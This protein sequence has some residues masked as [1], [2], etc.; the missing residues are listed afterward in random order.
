MVHYQPH[1]SAT[2][3]GNLAGA[4]TNIMGGCVRLCIQKFDESLRKDHKWQGWRGEPAELNLRMIH[5]KSCTGVVH[6][7]RQSPR[8]VVACMTG[9][10][11]FQHGQHMCRTCL[12]CV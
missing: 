10:G 9:A 7:L 8:L 1:P 3:A 11:R 12:I 4:L 6:M 5:N 2:M